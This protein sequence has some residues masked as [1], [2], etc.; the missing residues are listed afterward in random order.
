MCLV[1]SNFNVVG[2]FPKVTA[3]GHMVAV[4][5]VSKD[6]HF[7][8]SSSFLLFIN[9]YACSEDAS[10]EFDKEDSLTLIKPSLPTSKDVRSPPALRPAESGNVLSHGDPEEDKTE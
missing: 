6:T 4:S 7:K 9:R 3:G 8:F 1:E 2:Q 5:N 10:E